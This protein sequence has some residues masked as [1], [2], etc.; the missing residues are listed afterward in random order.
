MST[1]NIVWIARDSDGSLVMYQ[2]E[3]TYNESSGEW[4]PSGDDP[5]V[6][7]VELGPMKWPDIE[8][9]CCVMFEQ[10]IHYRQKFVCPSCKGTGTVYVDFEHPQWVR[11]GCSA[12]AEQ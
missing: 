8:P 9:A 5:T 10:K 11:C 3:P 4:E 2:Y 7:F 6:E 12:G 1:E